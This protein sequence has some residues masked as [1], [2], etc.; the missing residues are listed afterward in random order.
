MAEQVGD[1]RLIDVWADDGTIAEP[2]ADKKSIGWQ[3]L[4]QPAHEYFNWFFNLISGKWNHVSK[5]GVPLWHVARQ[6]QVNDLCSRDG[7]I[8]RAKVDSIGSPAA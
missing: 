5:Y 1:S 3:L 8:Y 6:Y 7:I 4:R 2:S